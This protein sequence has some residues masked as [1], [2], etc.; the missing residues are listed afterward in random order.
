MIGATHPRSHL[1]SHSRTRTTKYL[2]IDT[3]R[4][5]SRTHAHTQTYFLVGPSDILRFGDGLRGRG[6]VGDGGGYGGVGDD[7]G[8]G[9]HCLSEDRHKLL[10]MMVVVV[11]AVWWRE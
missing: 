3:A 4:T 11:M 2:F 10:L 5:H 7:Y 8:K 1:L 9:R 6:L